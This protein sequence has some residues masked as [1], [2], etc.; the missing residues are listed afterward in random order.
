MHGHQV[1]RRR[2]GD[3]PGADERAVP[4][5]PLLRGA[6]NRAVVQ[7]LAW[8]SGN[9]VVPNE[10]GERRIPW[11]KAYVDDR[12]PIGSDKTFA[13]LVETDP[14]FSEI[15]QGALGVDWFAAAPIKP[16]HAAQVE[17]GVRAFV[18]PE[19]GRS[20]VEADKQLHAEMVQA[21][22]AATSASNRVLTV[23]DDPFTDLATI[24]AAQHFVLEPD[25]YLPTEPDLLGVGADLR[26]EIIPDPEADIPQS[27]W[28]YTCVLIALFK[29]GGL[30]KAKELTGNDK[31]A[32]DVTK[33]VYALHDYYVGKRKLQ[34]DDG[35]ARMTI[36]GEWGYK[37]RWTGSV[38]WDD[39]PGQVELSAG[40]YIVDI[41]GHTLKLTVLKDIKS[42]TQITTIGE[43]FVDGSDKDN[44]DMSKTFKEQ[45][46]LKAIWKK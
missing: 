15:V 1:R 14:A 23:P 45:T 2:R 18:D 9:L 8:K 21:A 19:K 6:S 3:E 5:P 33:V 28:T 22:A 43:Y 12:E 29:D 26:K 7:R 41:D 38:K 31:L 4:E 39:L 27:Y 13:K 30:A 25:D 10:Y 46:K 16:A 44:W 40:D 20:K 34:Y 32:G 24:K 35:G 17:K 37:L 11:N 36:M 42:D